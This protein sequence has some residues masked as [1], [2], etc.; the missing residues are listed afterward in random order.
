MS[1]PACRRGGGGITILEEKDKRTE[2]AVNTKQ[3]AHFFIQFA[4]LILSI[5]DA[6][7]H[8]NKA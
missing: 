1:L 5:N 3:T 2:Y 8:K 7:A 4:K 6:Q